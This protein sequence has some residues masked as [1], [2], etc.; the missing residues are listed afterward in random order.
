MTH[1][2]ADEPYKDSTYRSDWEIPT[3]HLDTPGSIMQRFAGKFAQPP[4][5]PPTKSYDFTGPLARPPSGVPAIRLDGRDMAAFRP[6]L[7]TDYFEF[8]TSANRLDRLGRGWRW[9]TPCSAWPVPVCAGRP[10]GS[11]CATC[12]TR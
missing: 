7:S 4:V 6:I 12:R 5:G 10:G 1:E 3:T 8:G 2:F 9:A 11:S